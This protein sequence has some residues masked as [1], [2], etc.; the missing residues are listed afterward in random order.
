MEV[1]PKQNTSRGNIVE[2]LFKI[3]ITVL[4][5]YNIYIIQ[6]SMDVIFKLEMF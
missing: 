6:I 3:L 5:C 4:K 2:D 1:K